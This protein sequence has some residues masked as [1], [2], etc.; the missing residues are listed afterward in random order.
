M[1]IRV[2]GGAPIDA[3]T[4]ALVVP[5]FS[6]EAL[7]NAAQLAD[8]AVGGAIS[9]A[10]STGEF[11][12]AFGDT[13]L[14]HAIDRPFKR[15][16]AIGLGD[17]ARFEESSLARYAGVAVRMLGRRGLTEIAIALPSQ[18]A[19]H[20]TLAADTIAQG[21]IAASFEISTYQREPEKAVKVT[22][23][24]IL[25]DGLD[26]AALERGARNG[27]IVGEAVNLARRLAVTPANDMTPTILAREA[28]TAGRE[29]GLEVQVHDEAWAR[30]KGM[31]SFLS[32][33]RG[34]AEPPTFI[35]LRHNGDP[36]SKELLALVGKG[37]TFDTGGISIKP[38]ERME[39]MKYDMSGGAAVIAALCA[40]GKLNLKVNVVGI[41]PATENM[42]GG[43]ATKPGDIVTAMNGKTIEVINTD[44]EG[45]LIL[46]DALSYANEL[47]A[48]RIIDTATLT[49]AVVIALGHAAAAIVANDDALADRFVAASK[50]SGER[51]WRMPYYE[52]YAKQ[53]KSDIADLKNTGGR[54]AGTLTAAAFLKSFVADTPWVHVDIAGTAYLDGESGWQAKGPTGIPVRTFVALAESLANGDP[55]AGSNGTVS[56]AV[57]A[58]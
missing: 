36:T 8:G 34:S 56:A 44:A 52:D 25:S 9:E 7:A 35:V 22:A 13:L 2:A 23:V 4:A 29:A 55:S 37:I 3:R 5:V 27:T 32:V 19:G 51:F 40:I 26:A 41:V 20:E 14:V 21:A 24:T 33:A 54:P 17:R 1:Q 10:I 42:P 16:L 30:E 58:G 18:A 15:V 31:G 11:K 46:A 47:G 43:K 6:G 49:G 45:R 28:E 53:M 12:G 39:D 57:S 48:T 38:A 50:T